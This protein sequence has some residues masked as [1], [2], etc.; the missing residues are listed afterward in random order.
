M[1]RSE[2]R[3][4]A[5]VIL[6]QIDIYKKGNVDYNIEE[7]IK[8]NLEVDNEF[9]RDLVYGS[10]TYQDDIINLANKYLEKWEFKRL[11]ELS[12]EI[13]KIA[14]FELLYT[15]TPSIVIINEAINLS[16]KYSDT[17]VKGMINAIL[18]KI[19]KN[20]IKDK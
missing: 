13:L 9:V 10:V 6:Y 3:E 8:N 20:D 12:Q 5:M 1:T 4:K 17:K 2:L 18:D 7:V 19:L 11:D 14:I 15:D 16:D